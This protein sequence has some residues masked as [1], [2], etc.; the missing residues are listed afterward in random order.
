MDNLAGLDVKMLAEQHLKQKKHPGPKKDFVRFEKSEIHQS[1]PQRFEMQAKKYP[2]KIAVKSRTR[3]VTYSQLNKDSNCIA[4]GIISVTGRKSEPVV[5]ILEHG[6]PVI[7]G[8]FAVL[9]AG[10]IYIPLDPTLPPVRSRYIL[11]N[12]RAKLIVTNNRN[13]KQAEKWSENKLQILNIDQ[14]SSSLTP[15]NLDLSISPDDMAWCLYTS[16]S[17]GNPKGVIQN[18][19]NILHFTMNYTNKI[20]VSSD[21]NHS[22][23]YSCSFSGSATDIFAALLNGASLFPYNLRTENLTDLSRWLINEKVTIYH[24]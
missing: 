20:H 13:L 1:I 15:G 21:D 2:E 14:L 10:K 9:K 17:T 8:I 11:E 16:G 18:H 4:R 6:T 12:S 23:L 22:L 3:Q 7:T 5:L 24:S 19:R